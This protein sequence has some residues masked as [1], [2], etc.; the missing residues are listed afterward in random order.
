M[1][2]HSGRYERFAQSLIKSGI[3]VWAADMRGHGK[4]ADLSVNGARRG[5]LMGH[6]ADKNGDQRVSEDIDILNRRITETYP[7]IPFFL[8]GHSWG[9]FLVQNYLEQYRYP[10]AGAIL[11]GTR[12]PDGIKIAISV[13]LMQVISF[14]KGTRNTSRFARSLADGSLNNAFKPNRT[15]YDWISRDHA[16]VDRYAADPL[17]KNL[18][19][20][21]FYRDMALLLERIHRSENLQKIPKNLPVYIFSGASDPV[22]DNGVGPSKLANIY[23]ALGIKDLELVLYPGA[24]H[25]TLNETNYAEVTKNVLDWILRHIKP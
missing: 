25:E 21:G 12:G 2:E 15:P 4:T 17:C 19:S 23:R 5:G 8:M 1:A 13:P 16:E 20:A 18:C 14:V 6:C 24:R 9:S 3:A 22:G 11:S 7:D 10:L